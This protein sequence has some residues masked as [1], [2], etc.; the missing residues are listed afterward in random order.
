[1]FQ[2]PDDCLQTKILKPDIIITEF[3]FSN[4]NKQGLSLLNVLKSNYPRSRVIFLSSYGNVESAIQAIK[5]GAT[6]YILKSKFAFI[7]LLEKVNT[8]IS[9]KE[10]VRRNIATSRLLVATAGIL[11]MLIFGLV[12]IYTH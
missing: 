4:G 9:V 8:A 6:D 3:K 10:A 1:M 2:N 7:K 11:A 12:F 5:A